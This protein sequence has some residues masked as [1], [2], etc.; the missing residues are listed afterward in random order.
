MPLFKKGG[1]NFTDSR[2]R[3]S[4]KKLSNSRSSGV[5][6]ENNSQVSSTT[7]PSVQAVPPQPK[8]SS[9]LNS[10]SRAP[11]EPQTGVRQQPLEPPAPPPKF[12]FHCQLAHG[13][14]TGKV[15][16]FTNV[17][18]LYQKLAEVFKLQTSNEVCT[19]L[20]CLSLARSEY[21]FKTTAVIPFSL[22]IQTIDLHLIIPLCCSTCWLL[23]KLRLRLL[24]IVLFRIFRSTSKVIGILF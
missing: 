22:I 6:A 23:I 21:H 1:A 16:G 2:K 17:K 5:V 11:H 7:L 4:D 15:E 12:V 13:S 8:Q 10:A 18:E 14:P 19:A 3:D 24:R 9:N 20:R